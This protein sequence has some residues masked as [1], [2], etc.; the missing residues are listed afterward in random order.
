MSR[1]LSRQ[2]LRIL[3]PA[4]GTAFLVMACSDAPP[5]VREADTGPL[6]GDSAGIR[7]VQD[8]APAWGTTP[9]WTVGD[10][11][12]VDIGE[13]TQPLVGVAPVLRLSDGR[14][15]VVNG[16]QQ[17]IL[18]FDP[19]GKLLTTAGGRG[20]EEG[21]FHGLGWIGRGPAD[22][23]VAYDFLTRRFALFD[24]KGK[25]VRVAALAPADPKVA[26]EPLA[27]Y[28]DGS[29]LFR[30]GRPLN[31]FPGKPGEVIRDSASYMRFGLDGLPHAALGRFPQGET[32]GVRVRSEGPPSSF[33][34]PFGLVTVAALQADTMLIGTGASFEVASIGPD[35]KP[36][37]LLRAPIER[38]PVTAEMSSAVHRRRH[39]P[40]PD[41]R[42][43]PEHSAGQHPDP[44]AG[45]GALPR[46]DAGVR[47]DAGGP[48]R[49]PVAL[50]AA[51]S[52]GLGVHLERLR[53]RWH[54]ARDGH[55]AGR[56]ARGRNRRRLRDRRLAPA[57]RTGT[58]AGLSALPRRR[59]L[60]QSRL[61][62]SSSP[63][64]ISSS[65]LARAL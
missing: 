63:A 61:A 4:I 6:V 5:A 38:T 45:E 52:P 36:V 39:H 29:V 47:P 62:T 11:F 48:H 57:A 50:G 46:A 24:A 2:V 26:A 17:S 22:T 30:L 1:S 19:T 13:P 27:T 59:L 43:V 14:I 55:H 12:S 41:R 60:S 7:V 56:P 35:G 40:A 33:P 25:Y 31:P 9:Q 58:R 34:V 8:T 53:A 44:V 65:A 49:R 16:A 28:P 37:R 15:V 54:L 21:Q 23:V 51:Q 20:T 10:S 42:Q 3:A 18:Y 32:W 64:A